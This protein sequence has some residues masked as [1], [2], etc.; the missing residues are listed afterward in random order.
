MTTSPLP[1]FISSLSKYF[2]AESHYELIN[3]ISADTPESLVRV[4]FDENLYVTGK[5]RY[6]IVKDGIVVRDR[7]VDFVH[8]QGGFTEPVKMVMYFLFMFRDPRHRDFIC[9]EVGTDDG[10]WD[11]SIFRGGQSTYFAHVG[12]RKAFTNLRQFLFQTGILDEG[13][14]TVHIPE[15]SSFSDTASLP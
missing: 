13:S 14:W 1:Q 7:L 9:G 3:S 15:L 6:L 10:K 4:R 5:Q 11:T 2:R 8:D 12:G